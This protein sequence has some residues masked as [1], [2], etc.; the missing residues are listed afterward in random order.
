MVPKFIQAI[1]QK[2]LFT[3]NDSRLSLRDIQL[4]IRSVTQQRAEDRLKHERITTSRLFAIDAEL[5]PLK[6]RER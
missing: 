4:K 1:P 3:E 2:L 6:L 5:D